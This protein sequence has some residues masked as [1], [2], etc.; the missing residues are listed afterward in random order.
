MLASTVLV[1]SPYARWPLGE[2]ESSSFTLINTTIDDLEG[3]TE[4][5]WRLCANTSLDLLGNVLEHFRTIIHLLQ[6]VQVRDAIQ[7]ICSLVGESAQ[8]LGKTLFDLHEYALAWS[9]YTFSL[10]AAQAASN[11]ELWAVG[12]GRMSLLLIYWNQP[13]EALPLLQETQQLAVQ[14]PRIACWLAAVRAEVYAHLGDA[15]ACEAALHVA[16]GLAP[17]ASGG[18]DRYATGF[19]PSRLAGYEGACFVRLREPD[20]AL[21]ALQQALTLLDPQAIRRQS[22]LFTDMGIAYAQQGDM[23]RACQFAMQAL[24]ITTQTRSLSVLERVRQVYTELEPWKD[25]EDVKNLERQ[26]ETTTIRIAT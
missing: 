21:P 5:Y 9:Y 19:S 13:H 25:M 17:L 7:R 6:Q 3:I 8:I 26:L 14:N 20:R 15:E 4:R 11:Q 18:D 24:A 10:K 16:R 22:T 1:L 12:L 23:K 2:D